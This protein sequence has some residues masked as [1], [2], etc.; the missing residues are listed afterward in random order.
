VKDVV[1]VEPLRAQFFQRLRRG[2]RRSGYG[3]WKLFEHGAVPHRPRP[4]RPRGERSPTGP[5]PRPQHCPT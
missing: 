5:V 3:R 1:C 2:S 4:P